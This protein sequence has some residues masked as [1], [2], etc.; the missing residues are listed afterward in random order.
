MFD[1]NYYVERNRK[2]INFLAHI[3]WCLRGIINISFN[4]ERMCLNV[5]FTQLL[6]VSEL[7]PLFLFLFPK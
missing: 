7:V 1:I 2:N 4:S 3:G 5:C 6:F